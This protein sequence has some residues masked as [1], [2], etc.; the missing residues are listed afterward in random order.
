MRSPLERTKEFSKKMT[1]FRDLI[2][3]RRVSK[4]VNK[5]GWCFNYHNINFQ[6]PS[7]TEIAVANA[8]IKGKYEKEEVQMISSHVPPNKS[9]IELGGSFG[10]V[11][12]LISKNLNKGVEH[13]I[14]EANPLLSE[15]CL[16]NAKAGSSKTKITLVQKAICYGEKI[17]E[18][19]IAN[20]PHS[21]TI[22]ELPDKKIYKTVKIASITLNE[23]YKSLENQKDYTLICDIE[24]GEE[25]MARYDIETIAKAKT[26]IMELHPDMLQNGESQIPI[27]MADKGFIIKE[28]IGNVFSWARD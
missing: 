28:Q 8:L 27:L 11:S 6:L 13:I 17:I 1:K 21:S 14:V 2:R 7:N 25:E 23:I 16:T 15:V 9:V 22:F 26:V 5:N 4:H 18:F 12:G 24:G 19:K 3:K 10:I 20:N